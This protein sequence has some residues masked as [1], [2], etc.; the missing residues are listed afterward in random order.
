[1]QQS[2]YS[3]ICSISISIATIVFDFFLVFVQF[4]F[5]LSKP[6]PIIARVIVS[7]I[8]EARGETNG[9]VRN[10]LLF[11]FFPLVAGHHF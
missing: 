9:A 11:C 3:I 8:V 4:L 10:A 6:L 1:M 2:P 7:I 5:P